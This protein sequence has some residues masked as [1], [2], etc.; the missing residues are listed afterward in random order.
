VTDPLVWTIVL[1][2]ER[3]RETLRCLASLERLAY[4]NHRVLVVDNGSRDGSEQAIR[5][6]RPDVGFVQTGA[7]LGYAGGNNAGIRAALDAGAEFIWILN[8]DTEVEPDALDELVRI[9]S[10]DPHTAALATRL[11]E[12]GSGRTAADAFALVG[13]S[14]SALECDGCARDGAHPAGVLGGPSLFLRAEALREVGSFDV[15]YFHYYEEADLM[16]RLR[17]GGWSLGLACRAAIRHAHGGSLSYAS[18]QSQYYLLR[19]CL[20]YRRKLHHEHPLRFVAREPRMLR[21]ALGLR[22][23]LT[24]RDFRPTRAAVEA[25]ADAVRGRSGRRDLG[26]RYQQP[27]P[28]LVAYSPVEATLRPS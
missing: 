26:A 14:M 13:G 20:L 19:N 15:A 8:N 1:N 11:V 18:A 5:A 6:A 24:T 28:G 21:N 7:N 4:S 12:L 9:A 25:L 16:E 23:A 10:S 22:R 27:L 2:W 17:R 3:P